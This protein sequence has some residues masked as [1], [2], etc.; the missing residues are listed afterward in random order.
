[1]KLWLQKVWRGEATNGQARDT[2]MAI[3][4]VLLLV[5]LA[6]RRD[7]YVAAAIVV[8]VLNMTAP[9]LFKPFAVVW[10]S[11]SHALGLV[12]SRTLLTL[13]FFIVVTPMAVWRKLAGHD[14]LNLR[15]FKKGRESVMTPRNHTFSGKDL[16]QPY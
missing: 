10:F 2:G 11:L 16:E 5:W 9:P 15:A 8:H 12:V 7:G 1:M 3:V 14:S 4:L 6:Q 13:V